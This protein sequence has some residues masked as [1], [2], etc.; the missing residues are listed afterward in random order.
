MTSKRKKANKPHRPRP[1][2]LVQHTVEVQD[3]SDDNTV[4]LSDGEESSD[5]VFSTEEFSDPF[6]LA[7][8]E[9]GLR[10]RMV[11]A[12]PML[13]GRDAEYGSDFF[14]G[15]VGLCDKGPHLK[16]VAKC[17]HFITD[18]EIAA[19]WKTGVSKGRYEF[20]RCE[21][22]GQLKTFGQ[23]YFK[24]YGNRPHNNYFC[25]RFLRACFA[26]FVYKKQVNWCAEAL[27][28]HQSR[29]K[30]AFR[31]PSKL[32]PVATRCQEEGLCR[33]IKELSE[34]GG[35]VAVPNHQAGDLKLALELEQQKLGEV[36][37]VEERLQGT[38]QRYNASLER[39]RGESFE[40]DEEDLNEKYFSKLKEARQ[41]LRREGATV[42]Y[43]ETIAESESLYKALAHMR[44]S[45]AHIREN[46]VQL[47]V[48]MGNAAKIL[49][50]VTGEL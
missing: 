5:R 20:A 6:D 27:D 12:A 44:E 32:G 42:L 41:I 50:D 18:E 37:S 31:N 3:N 4:A 36:K 25:L 39:M 48:E 34:A 28:R 49:E 38:R 43:K 40:N 29:Q 45:D 23:Q 24:V 21:D 35:A 14:T 15:V 46:V 33:I 30:T 2:S 10:Q 8:F 9:E 11:V 1:E 22:D 17:Y 16:D 47:E 19:V 7:N 26:T 13:M